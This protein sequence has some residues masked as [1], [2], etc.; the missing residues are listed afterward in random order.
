MNKIKIHPFAYFFITIL[1]LELL[2]K[3]VIAKHFINSNLIY[4]LIFSLPFVLLLT[5][6][7]K[8]FNKRV[9]KI[10]CLLIVFIIT[11]YFEIQYIFFNLFSTPFSFSTISLAN[12]ALLLKMQ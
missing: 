9:N 5:I 4:M 10:I 7:A 2:T 8:A 6:L 1:Y 12:Q 11:V 3:I